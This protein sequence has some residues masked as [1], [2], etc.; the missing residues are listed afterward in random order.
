MDILP[1]NART[2]TFTVHLLLDPAGDLKGAA[3]LKVGDARL[4]G[5]H[6]MIDLA[7]GLAISGRL[8]LKL[9]D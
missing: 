2:W 6:L 9:K 4:D 5:D 7:A 3:M 8:V 1:D